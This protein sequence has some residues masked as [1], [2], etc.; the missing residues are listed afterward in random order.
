MT[1]QSPFTSLINTTDHTPSVARL[2]EIYDTGLIPPEK[3]PFLIDLHRAF[4]PFLAVEDGGLICDGASQIASHG[5]GFNAGA[6]FG[7]AQHLSSWT[8]NTR[9]PEYLGVRAAYEQLLQRKLGSDSFKAHFCASGA[10]AVESTLS[11]FF[12]RR[13]SPDRK[14]VLAFEGS[15]H[16]RMMVALASTWNPKKR[17][18]FAWPGYHSVFAPYPEIDGDDIH[19]EARVDGWKELWSQTADD[20]FA[21]ALVAVDYE[22]DP[23][24]ARE[25]ESLTAVRQHLASGE[26]F[27]ILVEPMQCE[28]GDRYASHRFHQGLAC[29]SVAFEV[30][31]VYDEIQTGFGLGGEF[32]WHRMLRLSHPD[33]GEF[34]PDGIIC[35]KKS[36]SGISI[37]RDADARPAEQVSAASV[38]RGYIQASVIDQFQASI[39]KIEQLNR[40]RM[41]RVAERYGDHIFRCRAK[42]MCFAFDVESPE[43]IAKLVSNRFQHG[44]LYYQAGSKTARFRLNLGYRE[45]E[46]QLF[47]DQLDAAMHATFVAN[48]EGGT[49]APA[50]ITNRDPKSYFEFHEHFIEKRLSRL[51]G[52]NLHSAAETLETIQ[53][54][55]TAARPKSDLHVLAL[56]PENYAEYRDRILAMQAAIYEPAR[57]SPPDEFDDLFK[58]DR[59]I[60]LLAMDGD[61]IAAM[62][63]AGPLALFKRE[64]GVTEDPC[65]EAPNVGYMLDLTVGESYRGGLGGT[66]KQAVL[67]LAQAHG[68]TAIHGRNRDRM[69]AGMWAINLSLGGYST[70]YLPDD[71][72]DDGE[73][74]DC[75]YYRNTVDWID[76]PIHLSSGINE[77]ITASELDSSYVH[78]ALP[79]LVNKMTLSNFVTRDFLGQ[80]EQVAKVFPENLRH[81]YTANGLAECVDKIVKVLW[82]HRKPRTRMLTIEGSRCGHGS[83]LSRSLS[84]VGDAFFCVERLPM[85]QGA[86]DEKFFAELEKHLATDDYLGF[87]VEPTMAKTMDRIPVDVLRRMVA[88]AKKHHVPI[89]F[90]DTASMFYRYSPDAFAASSVQG[91]EPDASIAF[92]GGQMAMVGCHADLFLDQPLLLI[93]TWEGDAFSLAAFHRAFERVQADPAA[94][95]REVDA[96]H[97]S[98]INMIGHTNHSLENG[99]GWFEHDSLPSRLDGLF[100]NVDGRWI[101]CPSYS[102]IVRFNHMLAAEAVKSP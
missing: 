52:G 94:F 20:G 27:A 8:N 25:I 69:A 17:E 87:V 90:N 54:M 6:L 12:D 59:P 45:E 4:G 97:S 47:W 86:N 43:V 53:R 57:Q 102:Q 11:W 66:M 70:S 10:E 60:A 18:P 16:G 21:S 55:V 37:V 65:C 95:A 83:F 64:R 50:P 68:Y 84:G 98:L 88:M 101:S 36:Q 78:Q 29:L 91:C 67:L 48:G 26:V 19:G 7:T 96:F 100:D 89:V 14:R 9:S 63:F 39:D 5:L 3:K 81:V 58:A 62:A 61:S 56:T 30:P 72:P 85:P 51:N 34:L 31:L 40:E 22:N 44:L 2:K 1:Q 38:I 33:G 49:N 93:S 23:T 24:L 76:E 13:P 42:G 79:V 71:Y 46:I 35:A 73:F 80:L 32:F 41:V 77:P 92:L 74:R 15:F 28:G 99:V 75:I 82:A